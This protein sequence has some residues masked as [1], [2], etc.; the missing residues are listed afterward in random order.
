MFNDAKLGTTYLTD[1]AL[2]VAVYSAERI[3]EILVSECEMTYDEAWDHFGF[4]IE[5]AWHGPATPLF[6]Y[7]RKG[8]L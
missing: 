1:R 3:V 5:N 7:E 4:N 8:G 2:H 6:L